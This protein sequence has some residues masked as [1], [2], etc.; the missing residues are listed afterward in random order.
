MM[1]A[2]SGRA[3]KMLEQFGL[4]MH[5]V[6]GDNNCLFHSFSFLMPG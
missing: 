3:Q 5:E 1:Y 6:P 2:F 4:Q